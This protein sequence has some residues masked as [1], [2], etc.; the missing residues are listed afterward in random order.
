[1]EE[2]E[3]TIRRSL[4]RSIYDNMLFE[5]FTLMFIKPKPFLDVSKS[6]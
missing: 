6:H 2:S 1:M 3:I 4:R 5:S